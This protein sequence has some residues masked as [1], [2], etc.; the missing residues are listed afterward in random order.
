M[1]TVSLC[2]I[3]KNEAD[4]LGR[5]LDGYKKVVDEIIV[6]DTGSDDNTKEIAAQYGAKLFDFEWTGDFSEARNYAFSK[7]S[8]DFVLSA[9]AD[10]VLDDENVERFKMLKE[11]ID[12]LD[13]DIVQMYYAGQLANETVYN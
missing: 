5:C 6:V 4:I 3:V 10:E 13:I 1:I 12:E 9:D 7:A 11:D 2:M 8:C